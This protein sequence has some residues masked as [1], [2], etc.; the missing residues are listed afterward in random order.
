VEDCILFNNTIL[1]LLP[2]FEKDILLFQIKDKGGLEVQLSGRTLDCVQ[3]LAL[4]KKEKKRD[5]CS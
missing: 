1:F 3:S 2:H 4:Q 5:K